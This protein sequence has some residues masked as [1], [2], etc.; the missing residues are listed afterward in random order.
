MASKGPAILDQ[1]IVHQGFSTFVVAKVRLADGAVLTREIED[2]GDAIAVLPYDPDRRA[3]LLV[4][5][6]RAP[7]LYKGAEPI[8]LEAAAGLIDK[9]ETAE[10]AARREA[11]EETGAELDRLEKVG[12][13]WASPG[14]STE[15]ISLYLAPC[16]FDGRG[17]GG[18][19]ADEHEGIEVVETPLSD[20]AAMIDAGTI[21]D[22]KL[23][24]LA[25]AL[26][27]RHPELFG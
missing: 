15:R 10:A 1:R 18:G 7:P 5:L 8:L 9:G 24:A 14:V 27:L 2:H 21:E 3:V 19:L 4:R 25:Q 17:E 23:L 12:R 26:R 20:L 11:D 22:M 6:F 16:S 13:L